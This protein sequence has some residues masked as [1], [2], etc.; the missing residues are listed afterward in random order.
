MSDPVLLPSGH[1]VDRATITRHLLS[2]STNPFN[3]A[4]L[5]VDMLKPS[6]HLSSFSLSHKLKLIHVFLS[7]TDTELKQQIDDWFSSKR[8]K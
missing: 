4:H 1:T 7:Q 2:D 6:E 3:R 5:T 8:K